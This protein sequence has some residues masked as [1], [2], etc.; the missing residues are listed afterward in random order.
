M[1]EGKAAQTQN[2]RMMKDDL[3]CLGIKF[4][5]YAVLGLYIPL[6][7]R[8]YVILSADDLDS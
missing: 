3:D 6:L 7:F 2:C 8:S 5:H 4:H 1:K